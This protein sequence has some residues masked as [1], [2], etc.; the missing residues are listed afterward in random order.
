MRFSFRISPYAL[1]NFS[2]LSTAKLAGMCREHTICI[3][4]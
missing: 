3:V 2:I 1:C 4:L